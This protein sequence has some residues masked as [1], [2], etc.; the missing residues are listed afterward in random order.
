MFV[1]EAILGVGKVRAD[2]TI[3][4]SDVLDLEGATDVIEGVTHTAVEF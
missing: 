2:A 3:G 4:V 1:L